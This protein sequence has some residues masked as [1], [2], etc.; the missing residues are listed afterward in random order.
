MTEQVQKW[1][2]TILLSIITVVMSVSATMLVGNVNTV[3]QKLDT[4][5]MQ[6]AI[7]SERIM[8]HNAEADEWKTRIESLETG[9]VDAT[10]DRITK[11]EA[12]AA[13]EDLRTWVEK[14]YERK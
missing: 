10:R 14:Y 8:G 1:S 9:Q 11:T 12:L 3:N 13:I 2:N 4:L 5:M 7:N 6:T